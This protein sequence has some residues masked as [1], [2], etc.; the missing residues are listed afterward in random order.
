[1]I[2]IRI[3]LAVL[4]GLVAAGV[5]RAEGA[6]VIAGGALEADNAAVVEA[7]IERAGG[8][9]D[10]RIAIISAASGYP[11]GSADDAAAMFARYGVE[12]GR[13]TPVKLAVMDDPDTEGLD[14]SDW[15]ANAD[16]PEEIAHIEQATG[17]WFTGGDQARLSTLLIAEDGTDTPMLEAMRA[18]LAAGAVIGGTSAGA[19][20][21]SPVMIARGEALPAL[22]EAPLVVRPGEDYPETERLVLAAGLG[23]FPYGVTDQHFGERARLG[24][25]ARAAAMQSAPLRLGVGVDENTALIVDLYTDE[26]MVRGAGAVTILNAREAGLTALE[27]GASLIEALSVSVLTDGDAIDLSTLDVT[28]ADYKA[29]TVGEEYFDRPVTDGGGMAVPAGPLQDL[30]GEQL[31][32]ND[33]ARALTRTSFSGRTGVT[34]AFAQTTASEG[35]W[36]RDESGARRY[37]VHAVSFDITPVRVETEPLAPASS[38]NESETP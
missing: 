12:A 20:M 4:A 27:S 23:F 17:V 1:M 33:G 32:D 37:A 36:G 21:M 8:A 16:A 35:W 26:A 19:A 29:E 10:A 11:S 5:A 15:A 2:R 9:E 13:I 28:P 6:L 30:L 31:L 3:I 22:L 18:R 7:F 38:Q 24:R 14:E 34:Y 25:L